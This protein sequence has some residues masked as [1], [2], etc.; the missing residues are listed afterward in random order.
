MELIDVTFG[1]GAY[2]IPDAYHTTVGLLKLPFAIPKFTIEK[3]DFLER[4]LH[5]SEH[6]DI[7]YQIYSD[8]PKDYIVKGRDISEMDDFLTDKLKVL[9]ES[10]NI[11]FR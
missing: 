10:L 11:E 7:D 2:L 5:L 9:I 6:K 8:F 1:E 4:F 3:K